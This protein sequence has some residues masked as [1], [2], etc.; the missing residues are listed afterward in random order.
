MNTLTTRRRHTSRAK[1]R[2]RRMMRRWRKRNPLATL[3]GHAPS[4]RRACSC[5]LC[6]RYCE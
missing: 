5:Q 3:V 1:A 4:N 2:R 6:Q